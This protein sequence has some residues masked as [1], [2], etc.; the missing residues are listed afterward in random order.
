M[1]AKPSPQPISSACKGRGSFHNR[2]G[3]ADHRFGQQVG[4][5][6]N[7]RPV[8]HVVVT[9]VPSDHTRIIQKAVRVRRPHQ[10]DGLTTQLVRRHLHRTGVLGSSRLEE[11]VD[12][13][14]RLIVTPLTIVSKTNSVTTTLTTLIVK[15]IIKT[16]LRLNLNAFDAVC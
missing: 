9:T 10:P 14:T 11:D 1:P 8:R 16:V 5:R 15:T 7:I 4:T 3:L 2:P 13:P 12:G 6:P